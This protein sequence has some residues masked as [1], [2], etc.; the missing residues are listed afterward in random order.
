[1]LTFHPMSEPNFPSPE[2]LQK[3]LSDFM[4]SQFGSHVS[5]STQMNPAEDGGNHRDAAGRD[6]VFEFR[7][8][9]KDIKAHLDRYVIR[10]DEAKRVLAIAV[11]DH[12]NNVNF[13]RKLEQEDEKKARETEYTKQNVI[14]LGPTGVGKTYLVK[15]IAELVGVPFV[16]ADATKFSETGYVGGDVEDLVRELVQRANGDI[17]LAQYGIIYIDEIDKIAS[18]SSAM[19]RDVSGR[20]V[21]TALLKLMEETDVPLRAPNDIQGQ[22]QAALEFKSS[23]GRP[24]RTTI[25]T[26]HIL[27]IV[28]GA[29]DKIRGFIERRVNHSTIGFATEKENLSD[30]EVME[31]VTTADFVEF[32]LEPEFIG[33]LPVRVV[34]RELAVADLFEILQRSEGSIVRQYERAFRAYG[35]EVFFEE[36]GLN[37]ISELAAEEK[38][39]ARGLLTVCERILR[40][41]KYEL[42]GSGV[43]RFTVDPTLIENPPARLAELLEQG[44]RAR[45]EE[46]GAVAREFAQRL[47]SR[48]S[49]KVELTDGAIARLVE[50][51][52]AENVH[53]RDLCADV[54]K[55]YEFGLKLA[56]GTTESLL[57]TEEAVANPDRYLSEWLVK[58][59]RAERRSGDEPA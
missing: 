34:C 26:R 43:N 55:D 17:D 36:A 5:V 24:R 48:H 47:S 44:Q 22:L 32:G 40:S 30:E 50:R 10:Q 18:S 20:G 15:H 6:D 37:R 35:I 3:K 57:L 58:R 53:M 45:A 33:R 42:P 46:L 11:C 7:H 2:E 56:E 4:K 9:P 8:L 23:G 14:L 38:T 59:Y 52:I 49:L 16:K 25:N 19:G 13:M 12:Y 27:F 28:S 41:F 21:Q 31:Q 1:M 54:F 51:A 39:G 29:F